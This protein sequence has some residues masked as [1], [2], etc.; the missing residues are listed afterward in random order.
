MRAAAERERGRH[1]SHR[2]DREPAEREETPLTGSTGQRPPGGSRPG[3]VETAAGT[4]LLYS[5]NQGV[6]L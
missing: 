2:G 4:S 6:G 1:G 3:Y 5:N